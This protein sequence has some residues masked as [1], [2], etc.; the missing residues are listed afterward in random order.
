MITFVHR[1]DSPA[2]PPRLQKVREPRTSST[3]TPQAKARDM[4]RHYVTSVMPDSFKGQVVIVS[5][6][7][8]VRYQ[9]AL[10]QARDELVAELEQL[11]R[12]DWT[13]QSR[14]DIHQEAIR[15]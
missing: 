5:R 3:T 4:L 2:I 13:H 1:P 7:L 9:Q 15:P 6:R 14:Q 12:T 10:V 8:A 11:S